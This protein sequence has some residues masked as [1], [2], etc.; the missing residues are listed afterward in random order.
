MAQVLEGFGE[1]FTLMDKDFVFCNV[2]CQNVAFHG[3]RQKL[4]QHVDTTK[5]LQN[6]AGTSTTEF[7]EDLC[8]AFVSA[9]IPLH[10]LN[11]PSLRSFLKKYTGRDIPHESTLRKNYISKQYDKT[12]ST[13]KS[14]LSDNYI[15]VSADETTDIKGR[16]IVNVVVG[17]LHQHPDSRPYLVSV[18]I[19]HKV[20]AEEI[21]NIIKNAVDKL[22]ISVDKILLF[23]SDAAAIMLKAGK[24]LK[25]YFPNAMH[26]TCFAHGLHRICEFIR[27]QFSDVN[28]LISTFKKFLLKA[29]SRVSLYKKECPNLPMPPQPV[30]TRWGT[31]LQAAFFYFQHFHSIRVFV[32]LLP[33]EA[34]SIK[35]CKQIVNKPGLYDQLQ[36]IEAHFKK[37][38]ECITFLE[39]QNLKLTVSFSRIEELFNELNTIVDPLR[40]KLKSKIDAVVSRN[41]DFT[42]LKE[43]SN[44]NFSNEAGFL[45]YNNLVPMFEYAPVTS[46]DVE[47]SF[48]RFKD[49][50]TPKRSS[51]SDENIEKIMI[52]QSLHNRGDDE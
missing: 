39:S 10:K 26:V 33:D 48:S 2:C 35:E 8:E 40:E 30:I 37:I 18:E 45:K 50:L 9:N 17:I 4:Q 27:E 7:Y 52:I 38:P 32:N 3:K 11:N 20:N 6:V 22:S 15:W 46:C 44:N 19:R 12:I 43:I 31:W 42:L 36:L 47:R 29:P 1:V 28:T 13:I 24:V 23:I 51:L 21:F 25:E 49:I 34:V 5:H 14:Q 41:P 16:C